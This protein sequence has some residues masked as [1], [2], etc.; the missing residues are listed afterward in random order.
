MWS[1]FWN[2]KAPASRVEV[3][4]RAG[5]VNA[6]KNCIPL[7]GRC[8]DDDRSKLIRQ[9]VVRRHALTLEGTGLDIRDEIR[10]GTVDLRS[11]AL[12][13]EVRH[14][15][16]DGEGRSTPTGLGGGER[17]EGAS[18]PAGHE[19][20]LTVDDANPSDA[21]FESKVCVMRGG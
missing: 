12:G 18:H 10:D 21:G 8:L 7:I 16:V 1:C 4:G 9:H 20:Q 15:D 6:N 19:R 14:T 17:W 13:G 11:K 3:R 2:W 5:W